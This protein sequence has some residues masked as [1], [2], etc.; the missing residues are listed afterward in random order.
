MKLTPDLIE[1]AF[2]YINNSTRDR[3]LDLRDYKISAIESLGATL[4]QF[5]SIDFT[6]NDI[7]R[8]EGFPLLQRLKRLYLSN[9]RITKIDDILYES[10]PNLEGLLMM[11]NQ[12][13]ELG[14]IDPLGKFPKL[15]VASFLGNPLTTKK[16]YRLYVIHRIP[17]LRLLDFKKIK[18]KEREE[19][20]KL[21]SG[22]EGRKLASEI[23]VRSKTFT[24]GAG[25]NKNG[26]GNR[27]PLTPEEVEAIKQAISKA[28]TLEEIERLNQLLKS[29]FIPGG[30]TGGLNLDH[31]MDY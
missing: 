3:E 24:P 1:G 26:V 7:K 10:L 28:K 2:Q 22:E 15:E 14:D 25:I 12:L 30:N 27:K 17:S 6:N 16:H 13:Q 21:F 23:G 5:D 31:P 29:G 18:M 9:N 20:S 8:L 4:D 11:N 19:A